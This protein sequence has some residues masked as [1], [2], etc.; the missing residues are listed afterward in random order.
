MT[1]EEFL[2]L[3]FEEAREVWLAGDGPKE[4]ERLH[5]IYANR[6]GMKLSAGGDQTGP[7]RIE[8][9]SGTTLGG[10][11]WLMLVAGVCAA[12]GGALADYPIVWLI[13]LGSAAANVGFFCILFGYIGKKLDLIAERL[14]AQSSRQDT[15]GP[16]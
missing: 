16:P 1:D 4:R 12:V 5:E 8:N 9:E 3:G 2:A 15:L 13:A 6:H 7:S 10:I 11:G 14:L